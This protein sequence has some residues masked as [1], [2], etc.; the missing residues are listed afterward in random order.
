MPGARLGVP[1]IFGGGRAL[2]PWEAFDRGTV[3]AT[4]TRGA[5]YARR[6]PVGM[7]DLGR[8]RALVDCVFFLYPTVEHAEAGTDFGGTG[9]FVSAQVPGHPDRWFVYAVSN[10]HVVKDTGNSVMRLNRT[11]G[12]H[13]SIE[14]EPHEWTHI[15]GG[16]DIAVRLLRVQEGDYKIQFLSPP[17]MFDPDNNLSQI[18][19][20]DD[21][22]MIGIFLDYDGIE[23]NEPALR[24]GNIS[25][26]SAPIKQPTGSYERSIVIDT[27]SRNG[28]SGS[29]VFVY[30]TTGG[31]FLE[32]SPH[33]MLVPMGHILK[34]LG[35][36]WGQFPEAWQL[37][38]QTGVKVGPAAQAALITD[39]AY[40]E[41]LSGMTCVIPAS[42][43]LEILDLPKLVEERI[44]I[45]KE[46]LPIDYTEARAEMRI[47]VQATNSAAKLPEI[48]S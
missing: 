1:G 17:I 44:N 46:I 40:V 5:P 24:F 21:V 9:F 39:G 38:S 2:E 10:W 19:V 47:S 28:Y 6:I 33:N 43:I 12:G 20:G 18:G 31:T 16:N 37:K 8:Y 27:H 7:P 11:D 15:P 22:F 25:I 14:T 36:H 26:M 13:D 29:P 48:K 3:R 42:R 45:T 30:R 23:T 4:S 34:L 35:I 32:S 41:G